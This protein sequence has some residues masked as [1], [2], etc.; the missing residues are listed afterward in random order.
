MASNKYYVSAGLQ[1]SKVGATVPGAGVN[2][3]YVAAG[4]P[5]LYIAAA[6]GGQPTMRRWGGIPHMRPG[7]KGAK[8]W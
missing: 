4:L 8:L 5:P 2:T 3:Y 6:A 1:V 7:N